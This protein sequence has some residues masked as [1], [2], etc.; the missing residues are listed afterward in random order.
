MNDAQVG[1]LNPLLRK[2]YAVQRRVGLHPFLPALDML[3]LSYPAL[4]GASGAPVFTL[5]NRTVVGVMVANWAREL[6]PAHILRTFSESGEVIEEEKYFL[7]N[8]LA[9][10][11]PAIHEIVAEAST[12]LFDY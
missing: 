8:G 7:P 6:L 5:S 4:S 2:G 3:E 1:I 10:S 9:V 12:A 11:F